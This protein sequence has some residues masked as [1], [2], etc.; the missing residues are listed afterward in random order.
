MEGCRP[1]IK[2]S[3][4]RWSSE[5]FCSNHPLNSLWIK[6]CTTG[7]HRRDRFLSR[8]DEESKGEIDRFG[9]QACSVLVD[10]WNHLDE[11][12]RG[13]VGSWWNQKIIIN[14][15]TQLELPIKNLVDLSRH[16]LSP[17][18]LDN[19]VSPNKQH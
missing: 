3:N 18:L 17:N 8:E 10:S 6:V 19:V 4:L 15:E 7:Q 9:R 5:Y 14:Q 12:R 13:S 11:S 16:R 2:F 1:S